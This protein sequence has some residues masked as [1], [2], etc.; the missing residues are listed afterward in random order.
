MH[1]EEGFNNCEVEARVNKYS[2][3]ISLKHVGKTL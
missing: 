3:Q 1:V 2:T